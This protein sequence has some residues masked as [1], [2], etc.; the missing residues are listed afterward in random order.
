MRSPVR[1]WLSAPIKNTPKSL[2]LLAFRGFLLFYTALQKSTNLYIFVQYLSVVS[3]VVKVRFFGLCYTSGKPVAMLVRTDRTPARSDADPTMSQS[4][5]C[6]TIVVPIVATAVCA[7]VLTALIRA[8]FQNSFVIVFSF[9]APKSILIRTPMIAV[10]VTPTPQ[11][12]AVSFVFIT[13]NS[14]SFFAMRSSNA[15]IRTSRSSN[16][17]HLFPNTSIHFPIW[18]HAIVTPER[19]DCALCFGS[20]YPIGFS[21]VV[22]SD[23]EDGL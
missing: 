15:L 17:H 4:T 9:H 8:A 7:M 3:G 6:M 18:I 14:T 20:E 2:Y 16:L 19:I 10:P 21:A 11:S 13:A 12:I 1:I 5:S 22:T 23:I